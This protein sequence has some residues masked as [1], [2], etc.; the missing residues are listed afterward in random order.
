MCSGSAGGGLDGL[1]GGGCPSGNC[2]GS[3]GANGGLLGGLLGGLGGG[4]GG[5]G[6]LLAIIALLMGLFG[7]FGGGQQASQESMKDVVARA[8]LEQVAPGQIGLERLED[9]TKQDFQNPPQPVVQA[10]DDVTRLLHDRKE[11]PLY[12]GNPMADQVRQQDAEKLLRDPQVQQVMKYCM[13][14]TIVDKEPAIRALHTAIWGTANEGENGRICCVEESAVGTPYDWILPS[15]KEYLVDSFVPVNRVD[16]FPMD[17][18]RAYKPEDVQKFKM[19][20]IKVVLS[21]SGDAAQNLQ[22]TVGDVASAIG[23]Q[24]PQTQLNAQE[25]RQL[26]QEFSLRLAQVNPK[27]LASAGLAAGVRVSAASI[28]PESFFTSDEYKERLSTELWSNA[29]LHEAQ[30][31]KVPDIESTQS[32]F[33][34]MMG[35]QYQYWYNPSMLANMQAKTG[36]FSLAEAYQE[37][38]GDPTIGY[39]ASASEDAGGGVVGSG[40]TPRRIGADLVSTGG[41]NILYNW[42]KQYPHFGD[43]RNVAPHDSQNE[44]LQAMRVAAVAYGEDQ[45]S[46]YPAALSDP[47]WKKL[48]LPVNGLS[49]EALKYGIGHVGMRLMSVGGKRNALACFGGNNESLDDPK[50]TPF[51]YGEGFGKESNYIE[52]GAQS[53]SMYVTFVPARM[54]PKGYVIHPQSGCGM[55]NLKENI[56]QDERPV[57]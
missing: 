48:G 35:R 37:W 18:A 50:K 20:R 14:P 22:E 7:G 44:F 52:T 47:S 30:F 51:R 38:K 56:S 45:K 31:K 32:K 23:A 46:Y 42:G 55:A 41:G 17:H 13:A 25:I 8:P 43:F 39:Q 6:G 16:I 28:R 36:W 54:C 49:P 11:D 10:R 40:R 24:A 2:G 5:G 34:S 4:Q 19:D 27:L 1:T 12:G 21:M 29:K 53:G 33:K 26:G 57:S 15:Q 3:Q 9:K